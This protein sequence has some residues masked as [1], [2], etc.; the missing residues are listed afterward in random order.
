MKAT[1]EYAGRF[2]QAREGGFVCPLCSGQFMHNRA[3]HRQLVALIRHPLA[4]E[5]WGDDDQEIVS[6]GHHPA[7]RFLAVLRQDADTAF[8]LDLLD[9]DD[10]ADSLTVSH[11]WRRYRPRSFREDGEWRGA[12]WTC[13]GPGPGACPF[14]VVRLP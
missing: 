7:A 4:P 2:E 8:A 13:D 14:T 10:P 3:E 5:V 6:R 1:L 11:V 9:I 12:W